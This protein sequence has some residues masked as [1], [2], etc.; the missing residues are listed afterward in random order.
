M[1]ET[2]ILNGKELSQKIRAEVKVQV[3]ELKGKCNKV[4]GLSVVLVGENPGSKVYVNMKK[5]ACL[6][7]GIDGKL[8]EYPENISE[9][10]LLGKINELNNDENVSGI[11]VQLPL[12]KHINEEK[13]VTSIKIGKDVDGFHPINVG[14]LMRD[15]GALEPCTP[16]GIIEI[17]KRYDIPLKGK[18]VVI[19]GRSFIVGKPLAFMFL[20]EHATVTICHSRT[21]DLHE[22]TKRADILVAAMGKPK[23]F[24]G[25]HIKQ[26]AIVIDVGTNRLPDGKLCGDVDFESAKEKASAITPSPGGVGP[27]T[28]AMLLANTVKA[29]RIQNKL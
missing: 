5:K 4:P 25:D 13:I 27:M 24:N 2:L 7:A 28:I 20:R 8:Y 12:P 10:D 1:N 23:F 26:G 19:V 14:N 18:D 17:L 11:L 3:E 9:A 16:L 15:K 22:Q 6:E 29:F 21:K